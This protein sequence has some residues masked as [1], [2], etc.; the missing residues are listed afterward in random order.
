MKTKTIRNVEAILSAVF[1]AGKD[2]HPAPEWSEMVMTAVRNVHAVGTMPVRLPDIPFKMMWRLAM[3]SAAAA[4]I[5]VMLYMAFPAQNSP[6]V[7]IV[8][9]PPSSFE[10]A[11]TAIAQM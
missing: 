7:T 5:C 6:S 10:N 9:V 3:G 4:L 1:R 2:L 8:E 11:I